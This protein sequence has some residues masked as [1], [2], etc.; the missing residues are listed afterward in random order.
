MSKNKSRDYTPLLCMQQSAIAQELTK[1]EPLV[2]GIANLLNIRCHQLLN[3][4]RF[5]NAKEAFLGDELERGG[6]Y[7]TCELADMVVAGDKEGF[8]HWEADTLVVDSYAVERE[9]SFIATSRA[10]RIA[11]LASG[12]ARRRKSQESQGTGT[13]VGT[14]VGTNKEINTTYGSISKDVPH[15]GARHV[16]DGAA[17]AA[18][19]GNKAT[20]ED[21][22][23]WRK[24][25]DYPKENQNTK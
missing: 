6:A 5:E 3:G 21:F 14:T 12:K 15:A 8:W 16:F 17:T 4:G 11:G 9:K 19:D 25:L 1:G 23:A 7:L 10:G 22:A 20:P 18:G 2:P 24:N 13:T